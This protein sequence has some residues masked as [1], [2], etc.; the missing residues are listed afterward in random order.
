MLLTSSVLLCCPWHLPVL[1][2]G[3]LPAHMNSHSFPFV[4]TEE[5]WFVTGTKAGNKSI[6]EP[7]L[8][9]TV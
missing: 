3:T 4:F 2:C 7:E 1:S 5:P 8:E 9:L 6:V